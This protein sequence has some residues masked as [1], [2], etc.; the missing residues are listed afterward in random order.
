MPKRPRSHQLEDIS[1]NHLHRK[2][3]EVG[4]TVEDLS[5]DYGED[6]FV[7]IFDKGK[8]TPFSFFV[9][10]KATDNLAS[11][12]D[13][14]TRNIHYRVTTEHLNHWRDFREPVI[15]TVYDASS[16]TTHWTCIQNALAR[17]PKTKDLTK[18]KTLRIVI[19][20]EDTLNT[21][22]LGRIREIAQHRHFRSQREADGAAVL[23]E[24]LKAKL[25]LEIEYSP[26]GLVILEGSEGYG[27]LIFFG[28]MAE[29]FQ[30]LCKKLNASPEAA[31]DTA[32][33]QVLKD[34]EVYER[35]GEYP[36]FNV[37]T[38]KVELR[39]LNHQ[40]VTAHIFDT[41]ER[42]SN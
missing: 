38:G 20:V 42:S 3:E 1:R 28:K 18:H 39:R 37:K 35:A 23:A 6:L 7:R 29:I 36:M 2:F 24:I 9:Q 41:L 12:L 30:K 33:Q 8:S 4:W 34:F 27:E 40:Q 10:S 26:N 13:R 17:L 32:V 16:D 19:S 14:D 15:L 25:D 21:N 31:L 22:G 11:Y 5:K